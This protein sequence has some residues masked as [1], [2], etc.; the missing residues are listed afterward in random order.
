LLRRTRR[1]RVFAEIHAP[2]LLPRRPRRPL[3][4]DF[5]LLTRTV[6]YCGIALLLLAGF[7]A[8]RW[9]FLRGTAAPT[10]APT[11]LPSAT[12][13]PTP[14]AIPP[15]ATFTPAPTLRP[16]RTPAPTS[17]ARSSSPNGW[18]PV[19]V[20]AFDDNASNWPVS[21]TAD[22]WGSVER[23]ISDGIYRWRV[24]ARRSVAR[25]CT[26]DN[27]SVADF[28]L[29]VDARRVS[30]PEDADYGL[31]FRHTEGN[32]YLFSIRDSGYY[33]FNL[34][35]E[36]AWTPVIDW[37]ET[38]AIRAGEV[39]HLVVVGQGITFTFSINAIE[40]ATV[41]DAQFSAGDVG[42]AVALTTPGDA[43]FEFDNFE[44]RELR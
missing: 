3:R 2:A 42:L 34:W 10:V 37:T 31:V 43:L 20:D 26:P 24:T 15:T 32:Y 11:P 36:F 39:N 16:T 35:Y 1:Q 41:G 25:W 44:L 30:G 27:A 22:E 8:A 7:F 23:A 28:Y 29:M 14:S 6:L 4:L 9:L 38:T 18:T 21:D 19:L 12:P 5:T 13:A 17:N 40:V 33:R